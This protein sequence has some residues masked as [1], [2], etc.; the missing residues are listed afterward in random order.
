MVKR[1][2]IISVSEF[3]ICLTCG[4]SF[5][6]KKRESNS[7]W[8]KKKFCCR[9]CVRYGPP[10]EEKRRKIGDANRGIHNGH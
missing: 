1:S 9:G 4:K 5:S 8:Q 2:G 7:I 3:K 10:S 6:K